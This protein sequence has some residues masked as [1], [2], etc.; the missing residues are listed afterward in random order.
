M[1]INKETLTSLPRRTLAVKSPD[2]V[3]TSGPVEASSAGAVVK[4]HRALRPSPAVDADAGETTD[5]VGTGRSVLA[6]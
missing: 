4:I 3:D 1:I 5:G 2:P 6:D